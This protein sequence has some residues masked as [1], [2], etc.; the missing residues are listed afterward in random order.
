MVHSLK[1]FRGRKM[2]IA[3]KLDLEK[4]Y[5]KVHWDFLEDR[6]L[7]AGFPSLLITVIMHCVSST[8]F[9]IL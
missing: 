1:G 4:A 6:L 5:D 3:V 9:Q 2:G 7:D 8:S